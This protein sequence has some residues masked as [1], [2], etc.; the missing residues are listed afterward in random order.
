MAVVI[1]RVP[2]DYITIRCEVC[3]GTGHD[4]SLPVPYD[5]YEFWDEAEYEGE[6]LECAGAGNVP[7]DVI[8]VA[9]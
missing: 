9:A 2:D 6:C 4:W 3:G 7:V 8:G 1:E 5:W